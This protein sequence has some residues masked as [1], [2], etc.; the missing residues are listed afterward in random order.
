MT[1]N[2]GQHLAVIPSFR[3]PKRGTMPPNLNPPSTFSAKE[4][5][6]LS[7]L[8]CRERAAPSFFNQNFEFF[9]PRRLCVP[10]GKEAWT[11]LPL[12]FQLPETGCPLIHYYN[13]N[14]LLLRS[15][16]LMP[17]R[18]I[19]HAFDFICTSVGLTC[20]NLTGLSYLIARSRRFNGMFKP[21]ERVLQR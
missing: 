7:T 13:R 16:G 10:L 17:N 6:N 5:D 11:T 18:A 19:G 2:D 9:L 20:H 12:A 14:F 8:R 21:Q 3:F 1:D 15:R 4:S